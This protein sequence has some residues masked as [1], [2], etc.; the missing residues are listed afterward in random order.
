MTGQPRRFYQTSKVPYETTF[1]YTYGVMMWRKVERIIHIQVLDV[2]ARPV[3]L[4][5]ILAVVVVVFWLLTNAMG[6][7]CSASLI[8]DYI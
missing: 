7:K 6:C 1:D 2:A 3:A 8:R 4:I 5:T